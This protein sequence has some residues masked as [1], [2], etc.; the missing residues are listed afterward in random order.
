MCECTIEFIDSL[1]EQGYSIN[2]ICIL[3]EYF[4][5][6]HAADCEGN[7]KLHQF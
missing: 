3:L 5:D 4:N 6:I 1:N 2:H 7:Y